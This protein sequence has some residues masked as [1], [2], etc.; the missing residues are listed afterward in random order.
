MVQIPKL[1]FAATVFVSD[2]YLM[3]D[4]MVAGSRIC[5]TRLIPAFY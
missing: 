3:V 1:M 5:S 2:W 4:L